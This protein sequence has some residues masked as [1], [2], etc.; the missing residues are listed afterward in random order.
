[1]TKMISSG[2]TNLP[3]PILIVLCLALLAARIATIVFD[4]WYPPPAVNDIS[5]Q[6]VPTPGERSGKSDPNAKPTLYL[7]LNVTPPLGFIFAKVIDYSVLNNR[8]V[9]SF[10]KEHFVPVKVEWQSDKNSDQVDALR[11]RYSV[12]AN[13]PDFIVA[14]PDGS[15]VAD[16]GFTSDRG[17][18]LFLRRSLVH[19]YWVTAVEYMHKGEYKA[20]AELY[21]KWLRETSTGRY[22]KLNGAIYRAL[23]LGLATNAAA[24]K[25]AAFESL[26][27][28]RDNNAGTNPLAV[29]VRQSS[30]SRL[31]GDWPEPCLRFLAGDM[32]EQDLLSTS[33]GSLAETEARFVIGMMNLING[34]ISK[35][36]EDLEFV[37]KKAAHNSDE[38]QIS[39]L[40]LAKLGI[41]LPEES[42]QE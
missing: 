3:S 41:Q 11:N 36:K 19:S 37:V 16:T 26:A 22:D 34:H 12:R 8:Q 42:D 29:M 10:L 17:F 2:R 23:A 18:E 33:D 35:A 39:R 15:F 13:L 30:G 7:F 27:Q 4:T 25:Q 40:Q 14:L 31:K 38:G 24:A 28:L 6:A 20:A 9:V 21:G 1:M 5:W 32:S